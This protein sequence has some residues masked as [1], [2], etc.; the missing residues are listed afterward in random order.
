[1]E[2]DEE[3]E[4]EM[5]DEEEEELIKQRFRAIEGN[6]YL[7]LIAGLFLVFRCYDYHLLK[8]YFSF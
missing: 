4:E 2:G 8:S 5:N 1:M 7:I 3:E 6:K